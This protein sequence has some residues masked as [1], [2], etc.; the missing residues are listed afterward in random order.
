MI[1]LYRDL[2]TSKL[3]DGGSPS[4][5][6]VYLLFYVIQIWKLFLEEQMR[7]SL[8]NSVKCVCH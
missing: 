2:E 5:L 7:I 8:D 6:L 1:L 4:A 3:K